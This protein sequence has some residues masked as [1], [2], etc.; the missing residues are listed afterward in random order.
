MCICICIRIH[1]MCVWGLGQARV[2]WISRALGVVNRE[3][4]TILP[5]AKE[6]NDIIKDSWAR[7]RQFSSF[8][9]IKTSAWTVSHVHT[10]TV[11]PRTT[12]ILKDCS[13]KLANKFLETT[14]PD[15]KYVR[16]NHWVNI[17]HALTPEPMSFCFKRVVIKSDS[18]GKANKMSC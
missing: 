6:L 11:H 15:I 7:A 13:V 9:Q 5:L 8:S 18:Q 10:S 4:K 1:R 12:C 16:L 17:Y 14:L 2:V 3:R